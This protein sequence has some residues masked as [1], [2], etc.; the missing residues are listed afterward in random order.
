MSASTPTDK[1]S[2]RKN[3]VF[4]HP[5]LGIGGAERLVVD[6]AVGLQNRGHKVTIF[7]NHCDPGHCFDETRDDLLLV[8]GRKTSIIK[9]AYRVPFD[10]AEEFC[11]GGSD[12]VVVNSKFTR[13]IV[14]REFPG[15]MKQI[16]LEKKEIKVVYPC[17][18]NAVESKEEEGDLWR[19]KKIILSINRFERKKDVDLAIR[20]FAGLDENER[21]GCRLVC[22]G[23]Y[24]SRV[25]ENVAY[26]KELVTL[27]ESYNLKTATQH[28][29]ATA[30]KVPSDI[31]VL[32][33]LSVPSAL[34]S[35]LLRTAKLLTYTPTN[36]HFGI[37]PV[38]AM[39]VGLPVLAADSGGPLETIEENI[40]GW[41]RDPQDTK[42][43]TAIMR[44]VLH[45]M[46]EEDLRTMGQKGKEKV[47]REFTEE[48]MAGR[49]DGYIEEMVRRPRSQAMGLPDLLLIIG[50]LGVVAIAFISIATKFLLGGFRDQRV[51]WQ[52]PPKDGAARSEL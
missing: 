7:T 52:S 44:K 41:H 21:K 10:W 23:G 51:W 46:S 6:A 26:H 1:K 45:E 9:R 47:Q 39:Q 27:A 11:L 8:K 40:T 25:P 43:W 49:L 30:L 28:N 42:A 31:N 16:R 32:F 13:G 38:E 35:T 12:A 4:F 48:M 18:T 20:A 14:E 15:L 3:I 22:A 34:K 33:L 19:D 36:E 50:A 2:D 29:L 37:V 17:V 24:D 5:D